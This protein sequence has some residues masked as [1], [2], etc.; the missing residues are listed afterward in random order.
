MTLCHVMTAELQPDEII[1]LKTSS[2][3]E[4]DVTRKEWGFYATPSLNGRL[5]RFDLRACLAENEEK[6]RYIL[7]VERGQENKFF[8][9]LVGQGMKLLYW[10]DGEEVL[11]APIQ[12][13]QPT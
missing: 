11:L 10:L 7:L 12:L 3:G 9:Y 4:F 6:L 1:T 5:K 8:E 2:G 13:D